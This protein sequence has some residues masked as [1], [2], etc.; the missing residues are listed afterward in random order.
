MDGG[1]MHIDDLLIKLLKM[2]MAMSILPLELRTGWMAGNLKTTSYSDGTPIPNIT[3]NDSW[4][5][6]TTGA[7]C[8]YDNLESNAA[9]YGR[10]YNW[11]AIN[12]GK[13][14]PE[15]WHVATDDEWNILENFLLSNGYNYDGTKDEDD[16]PNRICAKTN[17]AILI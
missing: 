15:G 17:R 14:A 13:L 11:Y 8:N 1:K 2:L 4:A 16:M 12:T 9:I 5:I 7:Y 3:D 10:L 6:L